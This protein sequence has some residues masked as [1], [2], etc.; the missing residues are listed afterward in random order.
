M[1]GGDGGP[2]CW[3]EKG[4]VWAPSLAVEVG[5]PMPRALQ[6]KQT[7]SFYP[8]LRMVKLWGSSPT[9][10]RRVGVIVLLQ[11]AMCLHSSQDPCGDE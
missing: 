3:A 6:D 9:E 10:T 4:L 2:G 1:E 8:L 5:Q 7:A 11:G